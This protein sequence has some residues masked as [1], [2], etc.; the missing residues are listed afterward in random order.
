MKYYAGIGSRKTPTDIRNLMTNIAKKLEIKNYILRNGGADGADDAFEAGANKKEIYL[1]S[2]SFNYRKANKDGYIDVNRLDNYKRAK[3]IAKT[4]HPSFYSLSDY[5]VKLMTRNTYQVMG[6]DLKTYSSFI[7]CWTP[8]GCVTDEKRSIKTGGTG[9]AI[10]IADN[11]SIPV[12][13]L[14][15]KDHRERIIKF[16]NN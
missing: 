4:F 14:H 8:D 3:K 5:A 13:N 1:P 15:R 10:S 12:F 7:I 6:K 16:V 9:Q 11:L 2:F